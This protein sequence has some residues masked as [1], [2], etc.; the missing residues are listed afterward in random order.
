MA[1]P[2]GRPSPRKGTG[3]I[4]TAVCPCGKTFQHRVVRNRT[5][6]Y[7]TLECSWVYS[8]KRG[9]KP[10]CE[11]WRKG[12]KGGYEAWNKGIPCS[13]EHKETLRNLYAGRAITPY[14]R[15]GK[16]S[17]MML[18]YLEI[19]GPLGYEMDSVYITAPTGGVYLLDFALKEAKVNVEI[20]GAS[21]RARQAQDAIRDAYL[22]SLGW[23]VIRV[24]HWR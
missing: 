19:L 1:W 11:S 17:P 18:E 12:M 4:R 20:D 9:R 15:G 21:H 13:E 14:G 16:P 22:K 24:R 8:T 3:Q 10:G 7:C 6:Q 5:K 23:T 2:E